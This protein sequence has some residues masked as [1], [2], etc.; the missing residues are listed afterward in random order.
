MENVI[1]KTGNYII[2]SCHHKKWRMRFSRNQIIWFLVF[3]AFVNPAYLDRFSAFGLFTT[4][5]KLLIF[6][7]FIVF[8]ALR[9]K[10]PVRIIPWFLYALLPTFTT[11]LKGGDIRKAL[12]YSFTVLSVALIFFYVNDC[13]VRD[14]I[15]GLALIMEILVL[16]NLLTIIIVPGGLYLYETEAGGQVFQQ[17]RY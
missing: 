4:I 15:A 9:N 17:Y 7:Y 10:F 16:I 13:H 14:M 8:K 11:V 6:V 5:V 1:A 12:I 3:L 2:K